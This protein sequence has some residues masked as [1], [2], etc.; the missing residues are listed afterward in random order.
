MEEDSTNE[1]STDELRDMG[2]S[3]MFCAYYRI[4]KDLGMYTNAISHVEGLGP[5]ISGGTFFDALWDGNEEKARR[6]ADGIN[7]QILEEM[8]AI[9]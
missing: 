8:K 7:T 9:A 3:A 4:C 5:D 1:F 2:A 6:H